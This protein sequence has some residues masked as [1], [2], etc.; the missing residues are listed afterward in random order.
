MRHIAIIRER[1]LR[2][3]GIFCDLDLTP[4][5]VALISKG[6]RL[7]DQSD[8]SLF[9]SLTNGAKA[10]MSLMPDTDFP[11]VKQV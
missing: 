4:G 2:D 11:I 8:E 6:K 5:D 7:I 1:N 10:K 9:I 3:Y